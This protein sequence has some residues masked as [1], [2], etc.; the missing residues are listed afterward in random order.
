MGPPTVK[1]KMTPAWQPRV[2]Y[3]LPGSHQTPSHDSRFTQCLWPQRSTGGPSTGS[4]PW[5]HS[6][7]TGDQA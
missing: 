5:T 7:F 3:S 4:R 1:N 2:A 6:P